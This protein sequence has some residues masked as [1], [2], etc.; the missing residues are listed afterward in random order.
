M[1]VLILACFFSLFSFDFGFYSLQ[2]K[3][4]LDISHVVDGRFL[5]VFVPAFIFV[6]LILLIEVTRL[7]SSL[8]NRSMNDNNLLSQSE[9]GKHLVMN[10]KI[11]FTFNAL[12]I[13]YIELD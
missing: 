10:S 2:F 4:G 11:V 6:Q 1:E 5:L 7:G 13:Y 3:L 9:K 12:C 8:E